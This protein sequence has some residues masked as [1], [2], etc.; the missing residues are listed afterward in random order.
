M[1][2]EKNALIELKGLFEE[3]KKVNDQREAEIKKYGDA[4]ADTKEKL[5]KMNARM[6]ELETKFNRPA[7]GETKEVNPE[8]EK[9]QAFEQFLRKGIV[10]TDKKALVESDDTLGGY[11]VPNEYVNQI[12]KGIVEFSPL[13]SIAS[14]RQTS[15]TDVWIPK[16]TS[17]FSAVW[18]AET[19]TRSE[20]TGLTYGLE[21]IPVHEM[22]AVVDI[23]MAELEDA[24]FDL[25]A[26][27][28]AEC[29]EQFG[30]A[31]GTAFISG[32]S[33]GKPQGILTNSSISH[34]PSGNANYLTADGLIALFYAI[35]S[36]YANNGYWV[37]NRS[38]LKA[39]RQLKDGTGNYLWSPN[40]GL[41][42]PP[43][44]LER[45]Y[46][47]ATDMPNVEAGAF[48]VAFGDFKRGYK[49]VDRVAI[50]ITRDPYTQAGS[51]KI[52]FAARKR[53]GGQVVLPEAI[54]L[55]EIASS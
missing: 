18:V 47:E 9:K 36:A 31:E 29:A 26:E 51:G 27:I 32:N 35:K 17:T 54:Q 6:D 4:L 52:R 33:I 53:V 39:I 45:P 7:Y 8:T 34:V 55:L 12:I 22:S 28:S 46:V 24:V 16:R 19:G 2:D 44:I 50:S 43:T 3:F 40:L 21:K 41:N 20:T 23:S 5:E 13:R 10:P 48:P 14:V 37:L 1:A 11:L 25:E 38:T 49:I 15:K 42:S 30:V